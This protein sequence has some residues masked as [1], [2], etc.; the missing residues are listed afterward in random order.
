MPQ[1]VVH[2]VVTQVLFLTVKHLH[3]ISSS[4]IR[5]LSGRAMIGG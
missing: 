1:L 3:G 2:S 5:D 4:N